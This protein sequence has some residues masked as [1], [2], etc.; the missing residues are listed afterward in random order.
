[1]RELN[2]KNYIQQH[3]KNQ[4]DGTFS[5]KLLSP[6]PSNP[7]PYHLNPN[8]MQPKTA[9][10]ERRYCIFVALERGLN[11]SRP[12]SIQPTVIESQIYNSVSLP[13]RLFPNE[14][15]LSNVVFYI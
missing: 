15:I 7:N 4:M 2:W 5:S 8:K 3:F 10:E 11:A 1:M 13:G 14:F 6:A 9:Q 12:A